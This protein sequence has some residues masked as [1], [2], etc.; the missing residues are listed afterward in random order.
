MCVCIYMYRSGWRIVSQRGETLTATVE[1]VAFTPT[2]TDNVST[3]INESAIS[4][5]KK[6]LAAVAKQG[7]VRNE[8]GKFM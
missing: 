8:S 2:Q 4:I 1:F 6:H 3:R 5:K 7:R